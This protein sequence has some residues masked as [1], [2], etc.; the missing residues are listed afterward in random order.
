MPEDVTLK[1]ML[2]VP[3][4]KKYLNRH[5]LKQRLK[6][7]KREKNITQTAVINILKTFIL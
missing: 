5:G 7:N 4:L 2:R 3:E 6:S 1:I